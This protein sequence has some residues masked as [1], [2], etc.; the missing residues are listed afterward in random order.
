PLTP[1]DAAVAVVA[2]VSGAWTGA[3][4]LVVAEELAE[5]LREPPFGN[6]DVAAAL[7]PALADAV[8]ALAPAVGPL[9]P[10]A[11]RRVDAAGVG[12]GAGALAVALHDGG[13]HVATFVLDVEAEPTA[14]AGRAAPVE[15]RA[16]AVGNRSLELLH[17]VEMAVAVELGRT[18]MAVRDLLALGPGSL[19]ELDRAAGSPVDVLVNGKLIARG[20]VVVIDEDFGIRISEIVARDGGR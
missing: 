15:A 13:R 8:A 20:E 6:E 19:V 2:A 1:G 10:G 7:E 12:F 17:D 11:A 4:A 3:V 14:V 18:R 9:T 16:P 5:L